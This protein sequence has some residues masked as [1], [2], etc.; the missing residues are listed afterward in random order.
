MPAFSVIIPLYNREDYIAR[1][2]TSVLVQTF[3]NFELIVVDDGSTDNGMAV[4]KGIR[5]HALRSFNRKIAEIRKLET[6]V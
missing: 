6:Q 1:A 3:D 2:I 5:T 4:V